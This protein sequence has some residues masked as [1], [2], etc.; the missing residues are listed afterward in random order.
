MLKSCLLPTATI[1]SNWLAILFSAGDFK[2]V[3]Q[4]AVKVHSTADAATEQE[5]SYTTES[6]ESDVFVCPQEGCVRVFQRHSSLEKHLSVETCT[7]TLEKHTL[8]DL[9]KLKYASILKESASSIPNIDPV[10]RKGSN[11]ASPFSDEG[12]ALRGAKKPYKFNEKQREYLEAKFDIGQGTGRKVSPEV[13]AREMRHAKDAGGEKLF[14]RSEFLS[15]QQISSYFSRL[16]AKGRSQLVSEMDLR[17]VEEEFN[18][19]SAREAV[20]STLD[21]QHPITYDQFNIC[22]LVRDRKLSKLKVGMLQMIVDAFNLESPV[23]PVRRKAPYLAALEEAV[24]KC[25]C[26]SGV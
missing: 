2:E 15:V 10:S 9:A 13:V 1:C 14:S 8:L 3:T 12:W 6:E 22:S 11:V 4:K 20:L 21:L 17:A 24:K 25:S 16:S 23:P 7:K 5:L 18:F 19:A 26:T